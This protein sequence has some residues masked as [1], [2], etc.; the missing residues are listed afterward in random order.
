MSLMMRPRF[1]QQ[2]GTQYGYNLYMGRPVELVMNTQAL[3]VDYS[4]QITDV[5]VLA[6]DRDEGKYMILCWSR[7]EKVSLAL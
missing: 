3:V 4:E 2:I 7:Q 5:S 6:M 1:F